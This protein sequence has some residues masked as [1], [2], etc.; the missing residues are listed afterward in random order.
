MTMLSHR[1]RALAN[2]LNLSTPLGLAIARAG[3]ATV[4]RGPDRLW[5]ADCYRGSFPKAGAFTIG[6]VVVVPGC[7][8]DDLSTRFP[9]LLEHEAAHARQWALCM[10]LPFLPFYGL[11]MAWSHLRTGTPHGANI[12]EV[13]ANLVKGGY[14]S[15]PRRSLR[16][17]RRVSGR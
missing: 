17:S 7:S 1:V 15:A 6:S 11:A 16:P 9:D 5:L 13:E 8:M 4:H 10:G 14:R 2:W 3:G 12:F